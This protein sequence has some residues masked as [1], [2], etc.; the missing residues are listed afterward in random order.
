MKTKL[1][2]ERDAKNKLLDE[3]REREAKDEA[4][5][6]AAQAAERKLKRAPDRIKLLSLAEQIALLPLPD[7]KEQE[8]REILLSVQGLLAKVVKYIND[9]AETL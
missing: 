7:L 1:Q 9:K 3:Q 4:E 5:R 8:A 2:K 6:K